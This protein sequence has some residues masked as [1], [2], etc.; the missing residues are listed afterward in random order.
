MGE[1]H[2][3]NQIYKKRAEYDQ[4]LTEEKIQAESNNVIVVE[5]K[6]YVENF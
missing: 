6:V 4:H 2:F 5:G 1:E 3:L